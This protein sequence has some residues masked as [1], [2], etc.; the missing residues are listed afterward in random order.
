MYVRNSKFYHYSV[1]NQ[2]KEETHGGNYTEDYFTDRVC[3]QAVQFIKDS[4]AGDK[5]FF[6]YV[7]TPAPHRPAT[8]APQYAN[9]FSDEVA[10]RTPS[11]GFSAPDKHWIIT[12]GRYSIII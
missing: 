12:N 6:M 10:P 1:S 2:G 5:P 8:P 11:Y 7:A 3:D 4:S 9:L